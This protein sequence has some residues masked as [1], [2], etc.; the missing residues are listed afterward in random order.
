ML[1]ANHRKILVADDGEGG[2][3]AFVTSANPHNPSANH[4]NTALSVWGEPADYVYAVLREDI[5]HCISLGPLYCNWHYQADKAYRKA[6]LDK[7]LPPATLNLEEPLTPS[8]DRTVAVR[9]LTEMEIARDVI[10]ALEN[11]KPGD[12]VR[13][14]MFTLA[15][16]PVLDAILQASTV[17]QTPIRLLLD[18]NKDA[19]NVKKIGTP[20]R[21]VA[22]YLLKKAAKRGGRI[23]VRW[24]STHGEQNH[25]KIMTIANPETGK[26]YMS[27]GSCNWTGRNMAGVNMESNIV[28]EG[29]EE[30]VREFNRYFDL[31]WTNKDGMEYS[32]DYEA[33]RDETGPDRKWRFGEKPYYYSAF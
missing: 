4:T 11:V 21:Q 24:Y 25:A 23:E 18:A 22:D 27:T 19:F 32:L 33:Y 8:V 30:T 9:F 12:E 31:F 26:W 6:Y 29:A 7:H 3:E 1:K 15:Y 16:Q 28:V 20:N 13:I 17:V 14:Q 2:F 10:A 5:A